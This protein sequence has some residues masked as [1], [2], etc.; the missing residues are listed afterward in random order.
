MERTKKKSFLLGYSMVL[1]WFLGWAFYNFTC[2][3]SVAHFRQPI[4]DLHGYSVVTVLDMSTWTTILVS[5]ILLFLPK[6]L[7]KWGGKRLIPI[8]AILGGI[9]FAL[10]P[11]SPT[12]L[13]LGVMIA[14]SNLFA[15]MYCS[16]STMTMVAKWFPRKKGIVMGIITACGVVSSSVLNPLF[17]KAMTNYG[18]TKAMII[19]GIVLVIFGVISIFW[20]KE[21]P[22]EAGLLPDNMP[23]TDE[24]RQ[25]L[26][27]AAQA[28]SDWRYRDLL[29][30]PRFWLVSLG[31]ACHLTGLTGFALTQV[32]YMGAKGM[33]MATIVGVVA[34]IGWVNMGTS[35]ASG[36]LDSKC[37]TSISIV[38][39]VGMQIIGLLGLGIFGKTATIPVVIVFWLLACGPTGAPNNLFS[40]Q[41]LNLFGGKSYGTAY[42][43]FLAIINLKALGQWIVA[44]SLE[45]TGGYYMGTLIC[46][47]LMACGLVLILLAGNKPI[48]AP[49][50]IEGA[51]E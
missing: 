25:K 11:Y 49:K 13:I 42:T 20:L 48:P 47:V 8:G 29:K 50:K 37:G 15:A 22:A 31:W 24:E 5:I 34:V 16:I 9:C 10:T 19:F 38:I 39:F 30:T 51:T 7:S 35:I 36:I 27:I 43:L 18:V 21:T 3:V 4:A 28:K 1:N 23:M 2:S 44:R 12:P 40:S 26:M 14:L 33:A 46:G 6:Y 32:S 41:V 45:A 17:N